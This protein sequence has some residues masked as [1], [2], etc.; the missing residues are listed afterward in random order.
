MSVCACMFSDGRG[1]EFSELSAPA[2]PAVL[3]FR[4]TGGV[5]AHH[6]SGTEEKR[7][8]CESACC[9]KKETGWCWK[10]KGEKYRSLHLQ[11][12]RERTH[13]P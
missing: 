2:P 9:L 12:E 1:G 10:E 13:F 6:D 3:Q 11:R 8:V 7:R 5:K 4:G